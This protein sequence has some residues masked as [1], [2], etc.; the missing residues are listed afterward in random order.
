MVKSI[1]KKK[2][3]GE[4]IET[5][6]KQSIIL[7]GNKSSPVISA[8]LPELNKLRSPSSAL[9]SKKHNEARPFENPENFQKFLSQNH[10]CL[11]ALGSNSKKRPNNLI[12][13]RT[14]EEELLDI[15]EFEVEDFTSANQFKV[16]IELGVKPLFLFQGDLFET[17]SIYT[18]IKNLFL[19]FFS[20]RPIDKVDAR[21]CEQLIAISAT[22]DGKIYFKQY[23]IAR[24]EP[25]LQEAG[26]SIVFKLRRHK[27]ADESKFK[28]ACKEPKLR[29]KV[30]NITTNTLKEKRGQL[31]VQQ[32]D[33]KTIALKKRN[34]KHKKKE[35][36]TNE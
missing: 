29:K 3:E 19:D 20:G 22:Q 18:R 28:Q 30:K 7:K 27:L 2:E 34:L 5:L 36:K 8:L 16:P 31:H 15:V 10:V 35:E 6:P 1:T 32:Q 12:I 21:G 33:I 25:R 26:P 24:T 13:G 4:I 17:D 11:F 9:F 23:H 14:Y